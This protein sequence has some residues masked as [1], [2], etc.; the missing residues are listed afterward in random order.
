MC[1]QCRPLAVLWCALVYALPKVH[2]WVGFS[3]SNSTSRLQHNL[4]ALNKHLA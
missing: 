1:S 2:F 3:H 4:L